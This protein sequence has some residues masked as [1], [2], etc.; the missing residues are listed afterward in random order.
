M[1]Q[2]VWR[3]IMSRNYKRYTDEEKLS[4]IK[5]CRSSGLSDYEWCRQNNISDSTFYYWIK[6]LRIQACECVPITT[7]C[8]SQKQEIVKVNIMPEKSLLHDVTQKIDN[9]YNTCPAIELS[10]NDC[11]L[12]V[13]NNVNSTLLAQTIN[14]LRGELC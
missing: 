13:Y 4:L 7:T 9:N 14:L 8:S 12:K 3:L 2:L 6:K 1:L 11:T 10:I 5:Q